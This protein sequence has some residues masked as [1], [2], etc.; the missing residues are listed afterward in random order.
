MPITPPAAKAP[1]MVVPSKTAKALPKTTVQNAPDDAKGRTATK[2]A[3]TRSGAAF[4]ETGVTANTTGFA[5]LST[6]GG[7]GTGGRLDVANSA[8]PVSADD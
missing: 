4:A 6:G 2:G 5:G 8:V 7:G 1:E 3:E